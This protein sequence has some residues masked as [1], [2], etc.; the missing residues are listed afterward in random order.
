M[1][2]NMYEW[3]SDAYGPYPST[4][5][6]TS[7]SSGQASSPQVDALRTSDEPDCRRVARGGSFRLG[8][9][10]DIAERNRYIRSA[11]RNHFVADG[12]CRIVGFRVVLASEVGE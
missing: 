2:G 8:T 12:V 5:S 9:S 10:E 4:T 7:T 1:H 11:S 6:T 3:C